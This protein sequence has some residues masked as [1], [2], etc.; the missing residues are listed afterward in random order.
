MVIYDHKHAQYFTGENVDPLPPGAIL[1]L[2][3]D[4]RRVEETGTAPMDPLNRTWWIRKETGWRI[5]K[6]V[7]SERPRSHADDAGL[8]QLLD[9]LLKRDKLV[10]FVAKRA[11][12]QTGDS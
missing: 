12:G 5:L 4:Q 11:D 7:N 2:T 10:E 3:W 6:G 1:R 8:V 9:L